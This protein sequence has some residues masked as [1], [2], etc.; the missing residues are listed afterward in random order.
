MKTVYK[1]GMVG[2]TNKYYV[3]YVKRSLNDFD[4]EKPEEEDDNLEVTW[5]F[6]VIEYKEIQ[7]VPQ[8][9]YTKKRNAGL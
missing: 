3:L 6:E 5:T 9:K 1:W 4:P 8:K 2:N 7:C